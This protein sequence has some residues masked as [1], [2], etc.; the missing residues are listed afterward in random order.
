MNKRAW[1]IAIVGSPSKLN[2]R[3]AAEE[4]GLQESSGPLRRSTA[5]NGAPASE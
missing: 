5:R 2:S 3:V 1:I 4:A